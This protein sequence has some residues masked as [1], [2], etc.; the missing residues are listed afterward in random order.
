MEGKVIEHTFIVENRGSIPLTILGYDVECSCT[1]VEYPEGEIA[2]GAKIPLIL[3]FD[4]NG[5]YG[6]Q[7]RVILLQTNT[8]KGIEELRFE[9]NVRSEK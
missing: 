9:V 2:P 3:R 5:K 4:T 6:Y 1:K 7:D 8:K